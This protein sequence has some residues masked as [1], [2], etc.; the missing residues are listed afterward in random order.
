MTTQ[1]RRTIIPVYAPINGFTYDRARL[2]K[3]L[4]EKC[5]DVAI[6]RSVVFKNQKSSHDTSVSLQIASDEA[7]KQTT[8]YE[9]NGSETQT[10]TGKYSTYRVL[11]ITRLPEDP[12]TTWHTYMERRGHKIA[13][14]HYYRKPWT[15]MKELED[16]YLREVVEQF[17]FEYVQTVR[18]ITM[19]PPAIGQIHVDT[20]T[21][22]NN[23]WLDDGFASIT[24]NVSSGGSLMRYSVGKQVYDASPEVPISHFNDAYRHGVPELKSVRHQIRI[25]GK[26]DCDKYREMMDLDQ[27]IWDPNAD[28]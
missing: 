12:I 11:N 27:A 9:E 8:H 13:F 15:W 7:L 17:P 20:P 4:E 22:A 6:E 16:S 3:E 1:D 24:L 2:Q 19:R 23:R 18:L 26:M 21:R 10:K 5:A 14:W 28:V 25:F